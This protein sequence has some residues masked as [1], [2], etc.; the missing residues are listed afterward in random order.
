L[1]AL[2]QIYRNNTYHFS[3]RIF[4]HPGALGKL[5]LRAQCSHTYAGEIKSIHTAKAA[6]GKDVTAKMLTHL[7]GE[8]RTKGLTRLSLETGSQPKFAPPST[9]SSATN[10]AHPSAI[11]LKTSINIL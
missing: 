10:A 8:A 1:S 4:H 7:E 2:P 11:M 3:Q 6:R 5:R 9:K